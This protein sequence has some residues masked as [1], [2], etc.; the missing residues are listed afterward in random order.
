MKKYIRNK[1][2]L[3]DMLEVIA[4]KM[5]VLTRDKIHEEINNA[6]K[7]YYAE[8]TPKK[9]ERTERFLNSLVKTEIKTR[10]KEMWCE[11]K[12]SESYLNYGYPHTGTF[13]PSYPHDYDGRFAMGRDVVNWAN[14]KYPHDDR[15][16]KKHGYT[17]EAK[18]YS[19]GFWDGSMKELGDILNLLRTNLLIQGIKVV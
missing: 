18:T 11:V 1:K 9:Y 3:Y 12:I 2:D 8:Y 7:L 13:K 15:P 16:G 5:L 19:D 10:G 14:R 6:I 17:K 4:Y